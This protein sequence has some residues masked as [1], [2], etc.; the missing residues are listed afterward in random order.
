MALLQSVII[1]ST[2]CNTA[3]MYT[4]HMYVLVD[5]MCTWSLNECTLCQYRILTFK[6][7]MH[8]KLCMQ[9]GHA[10]RIP[11]MILWHNHLGM[12]TIPQSLVSMFYWATFLPMWLFLWLRYISDPLLHHWAKQFDLYGCQDTFAG[13]LRDGSRPTFP[14]CNLNKAST[15][16]L[17]EAMK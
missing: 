16:E 5:G 2:S 1:A 15:T 3:C 12:K 10:Q 17:L 4:L 6:R 7:D 14:F 9:C 11:I 13:C 8:K